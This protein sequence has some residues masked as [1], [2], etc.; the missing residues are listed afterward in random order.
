MDIC[1]DGIEE[2]ASGFD[3]TDPYSKPALNP[4]WNSASNF[5]AVFEL[6]SGHTGVVETNFDVTPLIN[7]LDG[8]IGYADSS[9]GITAYRDM[10]MLVRMNE[11]GQFDVRNGSGYVSD[12]DVL[13]GV[14]ST[15]HV[16]MVTDLGAGTYDVW[17][18]PQGG[19]ETQIAKD[20]IFRSDAPPTDDLGKVCLIDSIGQFKVVNHTVATVNIS[21]DPND[22]DDDI[23]GYTE[24]DG[25]CNDN[26]GSVYPG[27]FEVCGDGIDQDCSG[28]DLTCPED[29]DNDGDGYTENQGDCNDNSATV[30]PGA[31]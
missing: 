3:P 7:R 10:A 4:A 19:T 14:N 21:V 20:Y 29:I 25:D 2:V 6:G 31:E 17:V 27:A 15:Y 11:N 28:A 30:Y 12:V 18:T 9:V 1:G 5:S 8:V 26:D 23:D 24:K 22:T 16:R 13:Y